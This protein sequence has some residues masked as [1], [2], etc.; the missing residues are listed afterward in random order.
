MGKRRSP[1][2]EQTPGTPVVSSTNHHWSRL[3]ER[4]AVL[5]T[6]SICAGEG[7]WQAARVTDIAVAGCRLAMVGEALRPAMA[8]QIMFP[9]FDARSG[10]VIWVRGDAAGC[11]FDTPMPAAILDHII[12]M[13]DP[14]ARG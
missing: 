12:R 5:V 13:S 2:A 10:H 1:P 4:R 9:G 6:T 14:A 7:E 11:A 8:I 3:V